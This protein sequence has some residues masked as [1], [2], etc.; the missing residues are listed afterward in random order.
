ML[1]K[2]FIVSS[3]LVLW[4][5]FLGVDYTMAAGSAFEIVGMN[6]YQL[7]KLMEGDESPI[8]EEPIKIELISKTNGYDVKSELES[9]NLLGSSRSKNVIACDPIT[10]CNQAYFDDTIESEGHLN[11]LLRVN[12]SLTDGK[13]TSIL[14]I[15][16][17]SRP[18]IKYTKDFSAATPVWVEKPPDQ[19]KNKA[20]KLHFS[21]TLTD[22]NI[23]SVVAVKPKRNKGVFHEFKMKRRIAEIII[24]QKNSQDD[25]EPT[26][27]P[28]AGKPITIE[29]V[30]TANI[31]DPKTGYI[32]KYKS[33]KKIGNNFEEK[34]PEFKNGK[35]YFSYEVSALKAGEK[36]TVKSNDGQTS[37]NE[38]TIR[39]GVEEIKIYQKNS[40]NQLEELDLKKNPPVAGKPVII[41]LVSI[42]DKY[43]PKITYT[44]KGYVTKSKFSNEELFLKLL[45]NK[46]LKNNNN[47][48]D[49]AYFDHETD[50]QRDKGEL[51]K[52]LDGL[53]LSNNEKN[54]ILTI[55]KASI[56]KTLK[57]EK[58]ADKPKEKGGKYYFSYELPVFNTDYEVT[59]K[60]ENGELSQTFIVQTELGE[61]KAYQE[62]TK[63]DI[64][65]FATVGKP[66]IVEIVDRI[67]PQITYT[68][69][70]EHG[71]DVATNENALKGEEKDN[72]HFSYT[73]P[74][75][76]LSAGNKVTVKNRGKVIR[77]FKVNGKRWYSLRAG[78]VYL[79]KS[80][81]VRAV[82]MIRLVYPPRDISKD[83]PLFWEKPKGD[84]WCKWL[85]IDQLF[86]RFDYNIGVTVTEGKKED[87]DNTKSNMFYLVGGSFELHKYFDFAGGYAISNEGGGQWYIGASMDLRLF[88][89][90]LNLL[91]T[92]VDTLAEGG[93]AKQ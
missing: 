3:A 56:G 49:I 8:A 31:S 27:F 23:G 92:T 76:V 16:Q 71:K 55:W 15:W 46:I 53:E 48:Q 33:D 51:R 59:V 75:D 24:S 35:Y 1:K 93:S 36:L 5:N 37:T 14:T 40:Q 80:E 63:A 38:L 7:D 65:T 41:K 79:G 19:L 50:E 47:N 13:I 86:G 88:G 10:T 52:R 73:I 26:A 11:R 91:S 29:L 69:K 67:E 74:E 21:Y 77:E 60:S 42:T 83:I 61:M 58:T 39:T 12:P 17:K 45:K 87:G 9:E 30:S 43:N 18:K 82:G 81:D 32:I 28:I 66:I 90:F 25:L 68:V 22:F 64:G 34:K 4:V 57:G 20:G 85:I 78:E 70:D 6:I 62:S 89:K 84:E 72:L 2:L 44:A 54:Y